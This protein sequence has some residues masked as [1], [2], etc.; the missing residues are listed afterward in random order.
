MDQSSAKETTA[1]RLIRH[2]DDIIYLAC[3][4]IVVALLLLFHQVLVAKL[5]IPRVIIGV[6]FILLDVYK[7]QAPW[8][9]RCTIMS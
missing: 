4:L 7:R 2:A 3:A 9:S 6:F 8:R 5:G 1:Q